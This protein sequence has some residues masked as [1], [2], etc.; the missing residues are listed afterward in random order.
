MAAFAVVDHT[1]NKGTLAEVAALMETYIETLDSTN[2]T[3]IYADIK[4]HGPYSYQG[5]VLS[6]G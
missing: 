1:T 5:V 2:N 6:T 3:L 4:E